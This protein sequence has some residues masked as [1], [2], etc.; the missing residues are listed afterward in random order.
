LLVL[1]FTLETAVP[2]G[3]RQEQT[4]TE[5]YARMIK[6]RLGAIDLNQIT[7]DALEALKCLYGGAAAHTVDNCALHQT[8]G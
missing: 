7:S 2:D 5:L 3:A 4:L 1:H 6:L 8:D